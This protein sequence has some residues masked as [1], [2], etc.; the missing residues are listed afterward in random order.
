MG[1]IGLRKATN[2]FFKLET[3][4]KKQKVFLLFHFN[5]HAWTIYQK[6]ES[7][8]QAVEGSFNYTLFAFTS[9]LVFLE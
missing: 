9:T 5:Y 8:A 7:F 1:L 2:G 6:L 4:I 3:R